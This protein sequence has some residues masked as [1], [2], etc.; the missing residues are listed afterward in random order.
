MVQNGGTEGDEPTRATM[1]YLFGTY[2]HTI[3]PKGRLA[4]PQRLRDRLI[5]G[6]RRTLTI[7]EGFEGCLFCYASREFEKILDQLHEQSF[8]NQEIRE[9]LRWLSAHGSEV[10]MDAQ[11]RIALTEEQRRVA[12]LSREG[13]L[14]GAGVRLE[15]WSPERFAARPNKSNGA[16]LAEGV[17]GGFVAPRHGETRPTDAGARVSP[18]EPGHDV[19]H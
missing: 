16:S 9:L 5:D 8:D 15:I 4:I 11:G 14:I 6:D 10:D 13:L 19:T 17:L 18:S 2:Q 7:L 12:G 3:D 1:R